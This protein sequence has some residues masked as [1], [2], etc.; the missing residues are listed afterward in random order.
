MSWGT[1]GTRRE[2][3]RAAEAAGKAGDDQ[4]DDH[5]YAAR[6]HEIDHCA[7]AG[8]QR[9]GDRQ[10]VDEPEKGHHEPEDVRDG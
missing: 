8:H 3:V 5:V 4:A 10:Q 6:N 1:G 9:P 2:V 7:V